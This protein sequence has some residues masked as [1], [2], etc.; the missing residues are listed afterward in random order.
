MPQK[1]MI[2]LDGSAEAE[3]VIPLVR[4]DLAAEDEVL[5]VQVVPPGRTQTIGSHVILG[6]QV[7][8]GSRAEA[9]RYLQDVLRREAGEAGFMELGRDRVRFCPGGHRVGGKPVPGR[10]HRYVHP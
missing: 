1:I 6:S 3:E 10:R 4:G 9:Q 8:E 2:P 5:L 7:E